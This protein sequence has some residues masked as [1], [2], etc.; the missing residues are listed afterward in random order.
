MMTKTCTHCREERRHTDFSVRQRHGW[1]DTD[2]VL[3]SSW[4]KHCVRLQTARWKATHQTKAHE[5][6]W[7]DSVKAKKQRIKDAVF[8]AYGGYVCHCCGESESRFLSLDHV[9]NDGATWRKETLGSRLAT[10]WQTYRWLWRH[11]FP[12]RYPLL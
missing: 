1:R 9:N 6:R 4:C 10:G 2:G 7:A 11:G 3:R 5:R 12:R 8:A